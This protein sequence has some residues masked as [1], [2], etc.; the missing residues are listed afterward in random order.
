MAARRLIIILV[1]LFVISIAAAAI[2]PTRRGP[3]IG[4]STSSSTTTTTSTSSAPS[5]AALTVRIDAST[6]EPET[7]EGFVGDQLELD[8]GSERARE[9][10]IAEFGV[11]EGAAS[12]APARF[13]LLLR[14][15]GR[16]PITDADTG[17]T[18]GRLVIEEPA[19]DTPA[20]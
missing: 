4:E 14:Y 16:F 10:E 15:A 7:V 5:G 6:A 12:D 3:L 19:G 1:V 2:A 18:V 13:N 8:V 9:I 20:G 11:T 17:D